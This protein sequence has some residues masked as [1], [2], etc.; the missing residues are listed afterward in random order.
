MTNSLVLLFLVCYINC[1][2]GYKNLQSLKSLEIQNTDKLMEFIAQTSY[3]EMNLCQKHSRLYLEER[4]SLTGWAY[5]S[6][7]IFIIGKRIY[8]DILWG[9][10][11]LSI[12]NWTVGTKNCFK[13]CSKC[14]NRRRFFQILW[15][16][17]NVLTLIPISFKVFD[18]TA[19]L[20]DG[21]ISGNNHLVGAIHECMDVET[22]S[23][24]NWNGS[25]ID[26]FK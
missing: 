11:R 15:P 13:L 22:P 24:L 2:F 25:L 4:K 20:P 1:A 3:D 5:R 12:P 6:N 21:L 9:C 8:S 18:A 14:K 16:S 7:F 23:L 17:Q 10:F 26:G 19:K